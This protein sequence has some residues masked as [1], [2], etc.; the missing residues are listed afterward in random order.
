MNQDQSEGKRQTQQNIFTGKNF[1]RGEV[2]RARD[3]NEAFVK[4]LMLSRL[5]IRNGMIQR[6][7]TC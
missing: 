4:P 6:P 3:M 2:L 5:K 1:V 7:G